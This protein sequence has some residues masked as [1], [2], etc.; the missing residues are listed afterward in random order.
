MIL[1]SITLMRHDMENSNRSEHPVEF[2]CNRV[3]TLIGESPQLIT[4]FNNARSALTPPAKQDDRPP[5]SATLNA[6]L[7]KMGATVKRWSHVPQLAKALINAGFRDQGDLKKAYT[8]RHHLLE[9]SII[10]L[11]KV[12]NY[13]AQIQGLYEKVVDRSL[14]QVVTY[15][16]TRPLTLSDYRTFL[17]LPRMMKQLYKYITDNASLL[18]EVN[19]IAKISGRGY[20]KVMIDFSRI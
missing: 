10:S 12:E 20:D 3:K 15:T 8:I 19:K 13:E 18:R 1:S 4:V 7:P 16:R 2:L 9:K 5:Y 14:P 17:F 6:D 11:A